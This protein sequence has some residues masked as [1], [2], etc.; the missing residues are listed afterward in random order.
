MV[1]SFITQQ[2]ISD[3]CWVGR[4]YHYYSYYC[5]LFGWFFSAFL[6]HPKQATQQIDLQATMVQIKWSAESVESTQSHTQ[7]HMREQRYSE[8]NKHST[9]YRFWDLQT[10]EFEKCASVRASIFLCVFVVLQIKVVGRTHFRLQQQHTIASC[11]V[12][13][14]VTVHF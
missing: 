7:T 11:A 4:L 5:C 1:L 6:V 12:F 2:C 10:V 13:N 9:A 8:N 14:I 3:R